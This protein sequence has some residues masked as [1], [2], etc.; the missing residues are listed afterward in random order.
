MSVEVPTRPA[1]VEWVAELDAQVTKARIELVDVRETLE[2]H[3]SLVTGYGDQVDTLN[4]FV[5]RPLWGR[6]RWLLTGR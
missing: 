1:S 6:L 5:N 4:Q 3:D 2:R